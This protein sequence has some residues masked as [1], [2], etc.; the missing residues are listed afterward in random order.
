MAYQENAYGVETTAQVV[1]G[2]FKNANDAHQAVTQ[3][4]GNGFTSNQI[5]AAF[6]SDTREG[7]EGYND[8][9]T[10]SG[11]AVVPEHESW[12]EK[13]KEAFRPDAGA[14]H[15]EGIPAARAGGG[16]ASEDY[17]NSEYGYDFASQDFEGSLTAAGIPAQ[18]ATYLTRNLAP[19]GAI[20]TVRDANRSEEAEEILAA[21]NAKVRYEDAVNSGVSDAVLPVNRDITGSKAPVEMPI[22]AANSSL[23]ETYEEPALANARDGEQNRVQLFGEVLRVHKERINRGEVRIRKDVI[24][25][26]QTIEVPVTHEELLLERVPVSGNTPAPSANIGRDQEIRIPL[27]EETVRLDKQ[28]VVREEVIVGK[29]DVSDVASLSENVRHEEL[30]VDS[31]VDTPKR[32]VTGE[33]LSEDVRRR[34]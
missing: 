7:Y 18:R 8:R 31:D 19:G 26:N 4:K 2:L 9:S 25:E 3:L 12:W 24:T 28:P 33:E 29:R 6:R 30:R 1:V 17:A 15:E 22:S 23:D 32:A 13:V 11:A 34:G 14:E 20:V 16:V 21:N 5:G 10:A 27:S